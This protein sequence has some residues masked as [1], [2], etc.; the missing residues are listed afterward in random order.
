MM[1]QTWRASLF[2]F[3]ADLSVVVYVHRCGCVVYIKSNKEVMLHCPEKTSFAGNGRHV[4]LL[5]TYF[6][7]LDLLQG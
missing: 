1:Y 3:I 6:I 7:Q 5:A 2:D 4:S